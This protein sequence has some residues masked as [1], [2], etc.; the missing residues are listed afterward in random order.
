MTHFP[1]ARLALC[2]VFLPFI[3]AGI[4]LA[5]PPPLPALQDSGEPSPSP[6]PDTPTC[7]ATP[8]A[9]ASATEAAETSPPPSVTAEA[10]EFTPTA[11]ASPPPEATDT[12]EPTG[13]STATIPPPGPESSATPQ[14]S[15]TPTATHSA[16]PTLEP[17]SAP[18]PPACAP[19]CILINEVAWGGTLAASS[20]EWIELHN[21]SSTAQSIDGWSLTDGGDLHL[22][23]AGEI[24]PYGYFLLERTDDSTV[25]DT[26]ADM[27]YTGALN[28]S[29]EQLQLR[30]PDGSLIDS[31]NIDGGPWPAGEAASRASME[32]VGG[33]DR[34]GNWRTFT[35]FGGN[36]HDASGAPIQGTPRMPNSIFFATPTAPVSTTPTSTATPGQVSFAPGS[37]LINELAWA[38]T[39]ASAS[40]EWIELYNPGDSPLDLSG[41]VLFDGGDLRVELEGTISA[42]G[43]FLLERTDDTT[44]SNIAADQLYSGSLSNAGESLSLLGPA[45]ELVDS[46]NPAGGAW[47]AGDPGSRASMERHGAGWSTF[48][49]Y[50][51]TGKD[52]RGQPVPGTPRSPN[53]VLFP[54]PQP[55]WIPGKL[56]I[57]EVLIRPHYD[58]QGTGGA[59]TGD[60]FIEILNLG[61]GPVNLRGFVLDDLPGAGSAPYELRPIVLEPGELRAFFRS[62]THIALNDGGDSV[63]LLSP[64]GS[65]IDSI[66]Y[67]RVR[68]YNLS[69]GRFPDGSG[70]LRYGLWPTPGM[71]NL[72]FDETPP[73]PTDPAACGQ[74][75]SLR[76]PRL[77]RLP[78]MSARL[79]LAGLAFC[80]LDRP[81]E[82][83]LGRVQ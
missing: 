44:I 75:G 64:S 12:S 35:G 24:A 6:L 31:A 60:E 16:T 29:G 54:T 43:Y 40:D 63:R 78:G 23:L 55:T 27:I 57:N 67:L 56:V 58:W 26:P 39:L 74:P 5:A 25:S 51:G 21:P 18:Q 81:G 83:G 13:T 8:R 30:A 4:Q 79:R 61:P 37:L 19:G 7:T 65:L 22:V 48:T 69:F 47:P 10:G 52:A 70:R 2:S 36:G 11:P 46:A 28:N 15:P 41:W 3:L 82:A 38:G 1:R 59:T 72:P 9:A 17:P 45:G 20:D 50:H 76:L 66:S 34:S 73:A 14:H 71:P 77:E 80:L 49:G 62:R 32:R 42:W 53:S 33:E 68:A